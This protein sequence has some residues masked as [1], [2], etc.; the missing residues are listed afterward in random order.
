MRAEVRDMLG[1]LRSGGITDARVLDAMA[2]V[3]REEFV[4]P[5]LR[6]E[7]YADRALG[8]GCEQTISQPLMVASM[9]QA[10]EVTPGARVL[11]VGTGSGYSAAVLAAM[12]ARVTSVERVPELA[13]TARERLQRLGVDVEVRLG[14]ASRGVDAVAAFDAI[15][16]AAS[17]P[18][19][20]VALVRQLGEGGRL[21]IPL[22]RDGEQYDRLTRL[23][24]VGGAWRTDDLGP[25][26]FVPLVGA[27]AWSDPGA[28]PG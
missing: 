16:V 24:V 7:A 27:D 6:S 22:R 1:T 25:C 10:M 26:L 9:L 18:R 12:G 13:S 20:P 4:P 2:Q 19:L 8:I 14:D 17:A 21:V 3:P 11:D 28:T 5:A 23:R 15:G